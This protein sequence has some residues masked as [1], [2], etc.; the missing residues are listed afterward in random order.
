MSGVPVKQFINESMES[1]MYSRSISLNSL[2]AGNY[3]V[4][5]NCGSKTSYVNLCVR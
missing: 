2:T 1:G 4:S 3:I 5:L